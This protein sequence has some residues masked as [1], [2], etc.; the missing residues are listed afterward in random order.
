MALTNGIEIPKSGNFTGALAFIGGTACL[1]INDTLV[2][3]ASTGLGLGQL[4]FVRGIFALVFVFFACWQ[5]GLHTQLYRMAEPKVVARSV[6]NTFAMFAYITALLNMP[7]ADASAIMQTVPLVLTALAVL[8]LNEQVGIRR[9][10]AIALGLGGALLI[11]KPGAGGLNPYM[12]VAVI[13]V[14]LVAAR[15][16]LTRMTS[17][18]IPSLLITLATAIAVLIGA[19]IVSLFETWQAL[20]WQTI[21]VLAT[22]AAFLMGGM[23]LMVI[24]TRVGELSVTAPFRYCFILWALFTGYIFWGELPDMFGF[25]GIALIT[26]S[27]IYALK[28]EA[29]VGAKP[30]RPSFRH[31]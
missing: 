25:A 11:V 23:H 20:S 10:L 12:L 19:G 17:S 2:K 3:L 28:R 7:I 4:I 21:A 22:A 14:F 27:G 6:A 31:H 29:K 8:F 24:A 13:A 9:W 15:D 1:I 26:L 18:D 16:L 5:A 30:K